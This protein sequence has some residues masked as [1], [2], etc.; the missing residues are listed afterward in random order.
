MDIGVHARGQRACTDD[1]TG[2]RATEDLS[3]TDVLLDGRS[4]W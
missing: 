2:V 3:A 4:G 1:L